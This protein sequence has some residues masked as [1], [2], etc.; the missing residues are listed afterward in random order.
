MPIITTQ[1]FPTFDVNNPTQVLAIPDN[2]N[3]VFDNYSFVFTLGNKVGRVSRNEAE[4]QYNGDYF[5]NVNNVPLRDSV[6]INDLN[7]LAPQVRDFVINEINRL[8]DINIEENVYHIIQAY[9]HGALTSLVQKIVYFAWH[10]C[11]I[12]ERL[13]PRSV[14]YSGRN[15]FLQQFE[16]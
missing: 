5:I 15:M 14:G 7:R 6:I 10:R 2:V 1:A 11:H 13:Y 4:W 16:L 9:N 12:E 3:R 8:K